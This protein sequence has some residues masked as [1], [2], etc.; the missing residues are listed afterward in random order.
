[1]SAYTENTE[2]DISPRAHLTIW[3]FFLVF[4]LLLY[5]TLTALTIY[6]RAEVEHEH[7]VKVGSVKSKELIELRSQEKDELVGIEQ[8][9]EKVVRAAK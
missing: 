4:G 3:G 9:M 1:M 5:V 2:H 8:A 6:F 7:Y